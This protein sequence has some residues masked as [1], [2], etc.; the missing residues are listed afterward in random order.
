[1][2]VFVELVP[3][4]K[5]SKLVK[6]EIGE[7]IGAEIFA[8]TRITVRK[9]ILVK[10]KGMPRSRKIENMVKGDEAMEMYQANTLPVASKVTWN[11]FNMLFD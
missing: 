5:I 6:S 10:P 3:T 2:Y 11:A 8:A 1:M 7:L 9:V 4:A